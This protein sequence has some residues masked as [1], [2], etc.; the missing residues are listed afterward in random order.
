[1][2]AF[3]FRCLLPV[4]G[5]GMTW[6][7]QATT[8]VSGHVSHPKGKGV[9]VYY[10]HD[11]ITGEPTGVAKGQL[12][13]KGNFRL[14]LP[15]LKTPTE[16]NFAHGEESTVL[17]LAPGDN[18]RLELDPARFD[19]S[20]RY[21]GT[22]ANV[23]NYLAQAFLKFDDYENL[24][25]PKPAAGTTPAEKVRNAAIAE[26]RQ[27]QA[28]LKTYAAAHPLPPAA[29][30]FARQSIALSYAANMLL[31][32]LQLG[33]APGSEKLPGDYFD[34]L[35]TVRPFQD[36][37]QAS[38]SSAYRQYLQYYTGV[39][40]RLAGAGTSQAL[41]AAATKQF[42]TSPSRDVVLTQYLTAE[43]NKDVSQ[44]GPLLAGLRPT[45]RD[46]TL[47]RQ[48]RA[49]YAKR[50]LLAN[51]QPAPGISVRDAGGKPVSL[52]DY[53]G[54]VVYLDFWASWCRP[55]LAEV[56]AGETLKKQFEGKDVVFLYVSIDD[57]EA[58]WKKALANHPLTSPNSVH[59]WAKGWEDPAPVAYQVTGIPAYFLIGRDGKLIS[60]NAPRPS[61]GEKTTTALTAALAK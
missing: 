52:A 20:L 47:A 37:A 28:F 48:V 25:E 30:A 13:A 14:E 50:L 23:N 36:S 9:V 4:L 56:P 29:R 35:A 34:F 1:M 43:M 59:G 6:A 24:P 27:R 12:D 16:A 21:T 40:P 38:G 58:N 5:L 55:C 45:L 7:A 54:K 2:S 17:F 10:G 33:A 57:E 49:T 61:E 42:G 18:L 32:P 19:E 39:L 60:N 46:S 8:I 22:G 3:S 44:V 11:L 15:A 53:R 51:G 26:R 41:L 31:L